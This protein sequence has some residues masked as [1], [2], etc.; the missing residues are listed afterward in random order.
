MQPSRILVGV[1]GGVAAF[2]ACFLVRRLRR[3]GHEVRVILTRSAARFVGAPTFHA[4]TSHRVYDDMWDPSA[5]EGGEPHVDLSAWADAAIVYPAT[6]DLVARVASGRSDDLLAATL[7]CL[8]RPLVV[9]PAMHARM[10]R[11]F[12][13]GEALKKLRMGGVTVL[14]AEVGELASGEVGEGRLPEP[15]A[16]VEAL[17]T[18]MTAKD[19]GGLRILVTAGPTREHLD[20]VRFLS[21]PSTGKMGY[22][23]ARLAL[24][25]GARVSLVTGPTDLVP[26]RGAEVERVESAAQMAAAVH[27]AFDGC[28]AVVMCAAVADFAPAEVSP[29]KVHKTGGPVSVELRPTEDILRSL[30]ERKGHRVL[31]GF[32]METDDLEGSARRKRA[33]KNLDLVV[34]NDVTTPGAGFGTDTNVVI[35]IGATGTIERLPRLPKEEVAHRILD[36]VAALAAERRS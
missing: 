29:R 22:A 30:G 25:R 12:F 33:A 36:R 1:S 21:N 7:L 6:A 4:L 17:Y 3:D 8:E 16:A 10:Y 5:A 15:D 32:A 13:F 31:V 18:R 11:N 34:G 9:C 14:E 27:R 26:P 35:L 20:P 23:V 28:D 24:R 2:K 19:L